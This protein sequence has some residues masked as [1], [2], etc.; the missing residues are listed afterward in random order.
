MSEPFDVSV[1]IPTRNRRAFF[2]D[3]LNQIATQDFAGRVQVVAS[4]N[5]SKDDTAQFVQSF[6]DSVFTRRGWEFTYA[7][8]TQT[9]PIQDNWNHLVE[10][11]K[12]KYFA[13][14]LD[15]DGWDTDYLSFTLGLLEKHPECAL[16]ICAG[17]NMGTDG[18]IMRGWVDSAFTTPPPLGD[19]LKPGVN[20]PAQILNFF[21]SRPGFNFSQLTFRNNERRFQK[22]DGTHFDV[23]YVLTRLLDGNVYVSPDEK[24]TV[25]I[26]PNSYGL[27]DILKTNADRELAISK[28]YLN[29]LSRLQVLPA[30]QPSLRDFAKRRATRSL[31]QFAKSVTA[32][33][34]VPGFVQ[35]ASAL[36]AGASSGTW[37]PVSNIQISRDDR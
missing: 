22:E 12:G 5:G 27:N 36:R 7:V 17:R 9:L 35:M 2:A 29:T 1:L 3:T 33:R 31:V 11:A 23:G 21:V 26:D 32:L 24:M 10:K 28:C 19:V 16:L 6:D 30:L 18:S 13:F 15:D 8:H 34:P 14:H 4:I 25:R 20:T 37:Q